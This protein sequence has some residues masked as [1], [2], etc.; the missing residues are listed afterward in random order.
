MYSIEQL[1]DALNHIDK[2]KYPDRV[3]IIEQYLENPGPRGNTNKDKT[4]TISKKSKV[5]LGLFSMEIL[6]VLKIL[7]QF[8]NLQHNDMRRIDYDRQ[9]RFR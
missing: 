3:K 2:D 8:F 4:I 1:K 7:C 6:G 9:I 5:V